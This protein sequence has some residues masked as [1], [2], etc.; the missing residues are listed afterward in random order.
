[1]EKRFFLGVAILL[2]FLVLGFLTM[3]WMDRANMAIAEDLKNAVAL[4]ESGDFLQGSQIAQRAKE[5]WKASW[6][7]I[8]FLADH[9]PMDEIDGLF[10]QMEVYAKTGQ[11]TDFGACCARIGELV[12]AVADAHRLTWWNFL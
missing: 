9:N 8:A 7:K 6:K 12:E 11:Q 3:A 2:V 4:V 10:S 1:M 5:S